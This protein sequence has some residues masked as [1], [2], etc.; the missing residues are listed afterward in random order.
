MSIPIIFIHRGN[1]DYL[2]YSLMQAHRSNPNSDI[3]LIG[4]ETNDK[5]DFVRHKDIRNYSKTARKFAEVYKHLSR[6]DYNYELFCI[7]RWFI[8]CEFMRKKQLNHVFYMDSD[9]MLFADITKEQENHFFAPLGMFYNDAPCAIGHSFF[10][11]DYVALEKMCEFMMR[12]Y[13]DSKL[14][15]H[16]SKLYKSNVEANV[17]WEI[18]DM[19]LL[20]MFLEHAPFAVQNIGKI[21]NQ[22]SFDWNINY[23]DGMESCNDRK[24]VYHLEGVPHT[25]QVQSGQWIKVQSLHMQ[26]YAKPFMQYFDDL[27]SRRKEKLQYFDYNRCEWVN[28]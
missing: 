22:S 28:A 20:K 6:N 25:K 4:D 2:K 27:G 11:N 12:C 7:E 26:G 10:A 14:F 9:V 21:Y 1:P 24:K 15:K 13:T 5:Y 17:G 16:I 18:S 23:P 19:V 3:V 8:L